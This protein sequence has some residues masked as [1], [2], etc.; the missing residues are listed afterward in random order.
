MK[1][2]LLA[3]AAM[4]VLS[5]PALAIRV[6][7]YSARLNALPDVQKRAVM[8]RAILDNG[9]FCK[10]IGKVSL[11]GPYKNLTMWT[12]S[13]QKGGPYAVYIGPD[14]SA[15]VRPCKDLPGLKLPACIIK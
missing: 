10:Q 13:C 14:G 6:D 2:M 1:T 8:R 9:Q 5:A 12:A 11:Q 3:A 7:A 15:Q 4:A